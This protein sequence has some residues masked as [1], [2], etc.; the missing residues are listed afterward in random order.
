MQELIA[1]R[2]INA[3][4]HPT[5]PLTIYNY[6]ASTQYEKKWNDVTMSC[7]GLIKHDDGRVIARPYRKFFNVGEHEDVVVPDAFEVFDKV[8]GSLGITYREPSTGRIAIA[9]RGSFE[10]EQAIRATV[11][12]R[13]RYDH[14]D[15]PEGQT[16]LFEIV[17]PWNRI[18]IKYDNTDL[19]LHGCVD[20]ATGADLPLP[21]WPGRTARAFPALS[22][23]T[24][25]AEARENAEGYILREHPTP[26]D[27]PAIRVKVK[28]AEYERLHKLIGGVTPHAI[29]SVLSKGESLMPALDGLPDEFYKDAT[30]CADRLRSTVAA[31]CEQAREKFSEVL[32]ATPDGDRKARALRIQE[33]PEH[34]R[35]AL[36]ALLSGRGPE[37]I[38]W[39]HCEPSGADPGARQ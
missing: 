12:W 7:R 37:P 15:V 27:R 20:I 23:E 2:Y 10:S 17:G 34:N 38:A 3:R 5:E 18:V 29:W 1:A 31:E 33:E 22:P 6:S 39:K 35:A 13:E 26:T 19:I 24:L 16:W 30:A 28:F 21:T 4:R 11:L 9:T 14:I 36:Y 8:D 32:T 25:K